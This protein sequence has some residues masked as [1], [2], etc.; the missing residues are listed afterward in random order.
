MDTITSSLGTLTLHIIV[1]CSEDIFLVIALGNPFKVN[2]Y[3]KVFN[4]CEIK[5]RILRLNIFSSLLFTLLYYFV[6]I[7]VSLI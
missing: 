6:S 7:K 1:K 5:R 2:T 3:I 4:T